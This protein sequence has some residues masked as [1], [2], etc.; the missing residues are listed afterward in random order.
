MR[1]FYTDPVGRTADL[2][3]YVDKKTTRLTVRDPSGDIV[4]QEE[5]CTWKDAITAMTKHSE[6][7]INDLTHAEL[8]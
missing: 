2:C 3:Q 5:Y 8:R 7:W 1:S 6:S 4:H